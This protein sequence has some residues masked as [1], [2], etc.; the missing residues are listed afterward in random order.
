MQHCAVCDVFHMLIEGAFVFISLV[1]RYIV[2]VVVCMHCMFCFMFSS[3]LY[4][5]VMYLWWLNA[6]CSE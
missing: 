6:V 4:L 3:L 1:L 5:C 2:K